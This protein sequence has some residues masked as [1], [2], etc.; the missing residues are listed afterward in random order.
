MR[1]LQRLTLIGIASFIGVFYLALVIIAAVV[2][3]G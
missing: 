2:A 3:S 1:C